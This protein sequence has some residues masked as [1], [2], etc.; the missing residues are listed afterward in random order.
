MMNDLGVIAMNLLNNA[1]LLAQFL[2]KEIVDGEDAF[3]NAQGELRK[4][5]RLV[6]LRA[7]RKSS[8]ATGTR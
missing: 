8:A 5:Q 4:S 7:G 3:G 6:A 1:D 2:P